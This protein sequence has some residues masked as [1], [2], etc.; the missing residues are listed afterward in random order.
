MTD[1]PYSLGRIYVQ[2]DRDFQL[3]HFLSDD[4]SLAQTALNELKLTTV[5]YQNYVNRVTNGTY[6]P[7]DGSGTHWG[8]AVAALNQIIS[9]VTPPPT[10]P[11]PPPAPTGDKVWS[12]AEADLDQGQYGTC[13]GNGWAQWGNTL[14]V[15]DKYTEGMGEPAT[16]GLPTA[17]AIYYEATVIDGQPDDPDAPGGGQQGSQ[18]RSGAKAM[19]NRGR[20][21]SYAFTTTI[22]T[23]QKY[24]QT[25]GPV[26]IG[27]DWTNDMFNPDANFYVKPTGGVAGGH[28]YVLLGD[29]PSENAFEF[30]NSWGSGWGNNGRFK[31]LY[32]DFAILLKGISSPGE[33]CA[34]LELPLA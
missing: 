21:S 18:V 10:P 4:V 29:L 26:V 3:E 2:D 25:N 22:S 11:P 34:A 9:G 5:T 13:V 7:A 15:D 6:N 32:T 17:R 23:I 31:M 12:N 33:A 19:Q 24:V 30:L 14:P 27:S 8:K 20:L 28:C 1:T 16:T